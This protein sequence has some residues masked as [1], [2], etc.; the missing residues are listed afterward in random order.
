MP[1]HAKIGGFTLSNSTYDTLKWIALILLPGLAA[2]Y[3]SLSGVLAVPYPDEVVGTI[4]VLDTLL[5][6]ILGQSTKNYTDPRE[7]E[8]IGFVRVDDSGPKTLFKFEYAGDDPYDIVQHD[9]VTFKVV[10]DNAP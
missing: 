6:V 9:R 4:T 10:K 1:D 8:M 3:F 7:G 5:G 2:A